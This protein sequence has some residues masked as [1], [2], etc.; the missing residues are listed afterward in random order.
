MSRA[1]S[2][3]YEEALARLQKFCAYQE[4]CHTDV[5]TKLIELKV[6]G[7][8]LEQ[9]I[10][11]LIQD[12]FLNELRYA[13]AF[14]SGKNRIN[15]WGKNKIAYA[16]KSKYVSEYCILKALSALDDEEYSN[17]LDRSLEK[18]VRRYNHLSRFDLQGKMYRYA[19]NR[20]FEKDDIN[21][22]IS[23]VLKKESIY[24]IE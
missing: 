8:S 14:A 15:G 19:Y 3:D 12:D 9:V 6:Y 13:I 24:N 17:M 1:N 23:K 20:G 16:L 10:A 7:D 22:A 18:Y 21:R 4:R 11:S 5:R 2:L